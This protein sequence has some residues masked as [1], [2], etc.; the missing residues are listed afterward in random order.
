MIHGYLFT[1][2]PKSAP[3][4]RLVISGASGTNGIR[5]SIHAPETLLTV[6]DV[7]VLD[8]EAT[9][10]VKS[11][12]EQ[13]QRYELPVT[14]FVIASLVNDERPG[15]HGSWEAFRKLHRAGHD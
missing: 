8:P 9:I 7:T 1:T 13:S 14:W 12:V 11:G 15:Y 6:Q 10:H 4:S 3:G 2:G 5:G